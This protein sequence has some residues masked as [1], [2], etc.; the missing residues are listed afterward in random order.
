MIPDS[1]KK[2]EFESFSYVDERR[3]GT[4]QTKQAIEYFAAWLDE[5]L[6]KLEA[7]FPQVATI[8]TFSHDNRGK[9]RHAK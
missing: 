8:P 6:V 4:A 5:E 9:R 2:D 1:T 3:A 7:R